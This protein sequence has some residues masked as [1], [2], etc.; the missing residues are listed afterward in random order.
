MLPVLF[1]LGPVTIYSYGFFMT[2]SY[3]VAAFILWREGKRQGYQ[4][5]KL[6]D[7]SL[8]ALVAALLVYR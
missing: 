6:F 5:E 2:L 4:P 7:L 8:I 3:L 1:K